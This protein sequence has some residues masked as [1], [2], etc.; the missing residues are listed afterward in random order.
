MKKLLTLLMLL[1]ASITANASLI[2]IDIEDKLYNIDDSLTVNIYI[3]DLIQPSGFQALIGGFSFDLLS[4]DSLLSLEQVIFGDKLDVDT[5]F[6]DPSIQIVDST[7]ANRSIIQETASAFTSDLLNAQG[8][9]SSFLLVSAEFKVMSQ[10]VANFALDNV[11][12]V[13]DFG[14]AHSLSAI[15]AR[16]VQLG[17]S[18]VSVPEP[19]VLIVF[20]LG[21]LMLIG[22]GRVKKQS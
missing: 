22:L 4:Q 15:Q 21:L 20:M 14:F 11:S 12:V 3:S 18:A 1:T 9:L 17:T 16:D 5:F 13:D 7:V 19:N 8:F 2:S 10:G 6:F